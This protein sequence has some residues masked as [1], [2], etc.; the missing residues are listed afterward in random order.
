MD[1]DSFNSGDWFNAVDW[2]LATTNWGRGLPVADKNA[3]NW[4]IMQPLLADPALAPEPG[5]LAQSASLFAELL[6]IRNSTRLFRLGQAGDVMER[7]AF[8]NTG[9]TQIPGL[10][11]MSISDDAADV[12][13]ANELVVTLFNAN[14]APVSFG[15]PAEGRVFELHPALAASVDPIAATAHY[16]TGAGAFSVPGRT[17]A[18]FLVQRPVSEQL[19][20]LIAE[21]EQLLADDVVNGG[22][23]NSLTA[24]LRAAQK[25]AANGRATAAA[26][27]VDAFINEVQ[28]L[29]SA[30]VLTAEDGAGLIAIAEQIL[31]S[32]R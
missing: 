16:D 2:S 17:T 6:A 27:Q 19:D 26:N 1:R 23:A 10:I 21:V 13:L 4:P 24:K 29:V 8:H 3:D 18:V 12:D 9:P 31:Q 30:G 28:A 20:V 15:F 5:D 25:S 7:V 22:Q 11:V 32:I 14:D